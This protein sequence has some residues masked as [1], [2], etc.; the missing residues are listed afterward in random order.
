MR[1][2]DQDLHHL[3]IEVDGRTICDAQVYSCNI[4][5][6]ENIEKYQVWGIIP[7]EKR[8]TYVVYHPVIKLHADCPGD[9]KFMEGV[10]W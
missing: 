3:V 2:S 9:V 5:R 7:G 10:L 6:N 1:D 4:E 8:G